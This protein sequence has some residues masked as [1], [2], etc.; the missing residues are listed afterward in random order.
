M[1]DWLARQLD[2]I[3][4]DAETWPTWK[5]REVG[6]MP[7]PAPPVDRQPPPRWQQIGNFLC[8]VIRTDRDFREVQQDSPDPPTAV[9]S[10]P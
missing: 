6:L 8:P 1:S 2:N 7:K 5:R 9:E 10:E 3:K 4:A